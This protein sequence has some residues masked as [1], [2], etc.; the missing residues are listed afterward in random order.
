MSGDETKPDAV[1]YLLRLLTRRD[2]AAAELDERMRRKGIAEDERSAAL[3][4]VRE[5]DLIDDAR[6]AEMHVRSHAH[7]KGRLALR[8]DLRARGLDDATVEAALRPLDEDQQIEAASGVLAKQRWRFASGDARKARAKAASFLSRR[9]FA[10]DVV[11]VALEAAA[12]EETAL[13]ATALEATDHEDRPEASDRSE[14]N[15]GTGG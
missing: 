14:R 9:G 15:D 3:D 1:A 13:E 10:G 6:V 11:A 4:R 5:L 2:Y 7:R 8:R 12:L